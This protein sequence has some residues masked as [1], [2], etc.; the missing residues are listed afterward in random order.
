MTDDSQRLSRLYGDSVDTVAARARANADGCL[1]GGVL[2]VMKHIPGH[3]RG[4]VDSHL[5]LP[6]VD[7]PIDALRDTD[8]EVFRRLNDLPLG[9]SAHVVYSA[10]DDVTAN[11]LYRQGRKAH[12]ARCEIRYREPLRVGETIALRGW[13]ERERGRLVVL[14]GEA[15]RLADGVPVADCEASFMLERL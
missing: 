8:F 11:V 4:T 12:T 13:I 7:T 3:G 1:H 2:P 6:R 15:V 14:K 9:M 10:L 5:G